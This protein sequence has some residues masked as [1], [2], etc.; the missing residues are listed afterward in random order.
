MSVQ[1]QGSLDAERE[2]SIQS[3]LVDRRS[4]WQ[5]MMDGLN[6][7]DLRPYMWV[8]AGISLVYPPSLYLFLPLLLFATFRFSSAGKNAGPPLYLPQ[9]SGLP[10]PND[11]KPGSRFMSSKNRF[12]LARGVFF[13][14]NSFQNA[15]ELWINRPSVL[16]HMLL[17]G[18]T[19]SGKTEVLLGFAYNY[20]LGGG[21]LQYND[22][23]GTKEL[24]W[25]LYTVARY[26]GREDDVRVINYIG[27]S[28]KDMDPADRLSNDCNPFA[29]GSHEDLTQLTVQLASGGADSGGGDANKV[30]QDR[31]VTL[32]S[33][34]LPALCELR[35]QGL[36]A[37]NASNLRKHL[38]WDEL[39][40]LIDVN[41]FPSLSD[42]SRAK[43]NAYLATCS[44]FRPGKPAD[45][46]TDEPIKQHGYAAAYLTRSLSTIADT[47]RGV[48]E[49]EAAEADFADFAVN[50]RIFGTILPAL[51]KSPDEIMMLGK[52]VLA[53]LKN[54]AG[55]SLKGGIEGA[56]EDVLDTQITA[57][58]APTGIICD[59][60]AYMLPPG[61]AVT[62]AQ[63]RGLGY[64][65]V[66]AGQ[67]K[68]GLENAGERD[69]A[70][71]IANTKTKLFMEQ[72][73]AGS[74]MKLVDDVFG[75]GMYEAVSGGE[76]GSNS[77]TTDSGST[78]YKS[79]RRVDQKDM[80]A[81]NT[82]EFLVEH[83]GKMI[84]A[85]SFYHGFSRDSNEFARH[86]TLAQPCKLARPQRGAAALMMVVGGPA[87]AQ[88]IQQWWHN[89][90]EAAIEV[91][92]QPTR[93]PQKLI[94]LGNRMRRL[95]A[96]DPYLQDRLSALSRWSLARFHE[97]QGPGGYDDYEDY[98][99]ND[100]E[101]SSGNTAQGTVP[102][103]KFEG[104]GEDWHREQLD[105]HFGGG[106]DAPVVRPDRTLPPP[107]RSTGRKHRTPPVEEP[108]DAVDKPL[109]SGI[110]Q[111]LEQHD[112]DVN[113]K[114]DAGADV[115]LVAE[116]TGATDGEGAA[117]ASTK[118]LME[119]VLSV[120]A[121]V[122]LDVYESDL[123]P[124]VTGEPDE[125]DQSLE[126]LSGLK[127]GRIGSDDVQVTPEDDIAGAESLNLWLSSDS[128]FPQD[129]AAG[130]DDDV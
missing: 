92:E 14:G 80:R 15:R 61:F 97:Q 45:E 125:E 22:A 81:L 104:A 46:Q 65:I 57:Y 24:F 103:P 99:D 114:A 89:A 107:A 64:S 112:A 95:A 100:D 87:M 115:P 62:V 16:T 34:V 90:G 67:D 120:I 69:A 63:M 12:N 108:V 31:S 93:L 5:Q 36:M 38:E 85:Q 60:A 10:D 105:S 58:K 47:Y 19:G 102:P 8:A 59:E 33:Q 121:P 21:G 101:D 79:S 37:L 56:V 53:M 110:V 98:A 74:T 6:N 52:L 41:E 73:D 13:L 30:F 118:A 39:M 2:I 88:S 28:N 44:G 111:Y 76:K 9:E 50:N 78:Q 54:A 124:R 75:E 96:D 43:I 18:T 109:P 106:E 23:K 26:L 129:D 83:K 126:H 94:K 84:W 3:T 4:G 91:V 122:E 86:V 17:F 113:K 32:V 119:Q 35:D 29:S 128:S 66:I 25:Q 77:R 48:F 68:A 117:D 42:D 82:G 127:A 72:A 40:M 51:E 55:Q 27:A 70:Q 116:A 20:L 123:A 130:E 49:T 7:A 11:P 71:Y 1:Q